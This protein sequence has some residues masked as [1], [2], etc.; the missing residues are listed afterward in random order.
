MISSANSSQRSY[1]IKGCIPEPFSKAK[2]K[3][4]HQSWLKN[5]CQVMMPHTLVCMYVW[6]MY[7][8]MYVVCTTLLLIFAKKWLNQGKQCINTYKSISF[9]APQHSS[10]AIQVWLGDARGGWTWGEA[11]LMKSPCWTIGKL[12]LQPAFLCSCTHKYLQ[13]EHRKGFFGAPHPANTTVCFLE[14]SV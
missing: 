9:L 7:V 8:C 5:I 10:P 3:H 11:T 4:F 13:T 1:N 14:F 12:S 6:C 2:Y